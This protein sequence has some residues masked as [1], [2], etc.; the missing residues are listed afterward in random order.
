MGGLV[1]YFFL[2]ILE[3]PLDLIADVVHKWSRFIKIFSQKNLKFVSKKRNNSI[4]FDLG[5]VLLP[6]KVGLVSKKK[7]QKDALVALGF[8]SI[9]MIFKLLTKIIKFHVQVFIVQVR[10]F[11]LEKP[12]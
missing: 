5:L 10:I 1:L 9:E 2:L 12:I 3:I 4:V 7:L 6:T 8:S 11:G